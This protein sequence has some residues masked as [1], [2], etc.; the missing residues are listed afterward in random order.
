MS[1]TK[2]WMKVVCTIV[3]LE[4]AVM[5]MLNMRGKQQPAEE[6]EDEQQEAMMIDEESQCDL[7]HGA[8]YVAP[9]TGTKFH[10]T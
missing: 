10:K 9:K 7:G 3:M 5:V 4:F 6:G 8:A 1:E 2:F